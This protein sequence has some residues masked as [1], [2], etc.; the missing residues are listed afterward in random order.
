MMFDLEVSSFCMVEIVGEP[1]RLCILQEGYYDN[2]LHVGPYCGDNHSGNEHR[3]IKRIV[4]GMDNECLHPNYRGTGA[5]K[6]ERY[7][8][9]S[10]M[11]VVVVR[12]VTYVSQHFAVNLGGMSIMGVQ[13]ISSFV[14]LPFCLINQ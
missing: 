9:V 13:A 14:F 4:S 8:L 6:G 10:G 12:W 2:R 5:R 1:R 7:F 3:T 11:F